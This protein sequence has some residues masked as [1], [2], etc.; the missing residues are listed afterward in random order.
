MSLLNHRDRNW[1]HI[2]VT[3]LFG[4]NYFSSLTQSRQD[5]SSPKYFTAKSRQKQQTAHSLAEA[6]LQWIQH[7]DIALFSHGVC[8]KET[9][10]RIKGWRELFDVDTSC[11][12]DYV[13]N[14]KM[15]QIK[16][17]KFRTRIN[18]TAEVKIC[19][20]VEYRWMKFRRVTWYELWLCTREWT[21]NIKEVNTKHNFFFFIFN[22][23]FKRDLICW[24]F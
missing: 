22:F 21:M 8:K 5:A 17:G 23:P 20:R 4:V 24:R 19:A 14:P 9:T 13:T 1:Y 2:N 16:Q 3:N 15:Y 11:M 12:D 18:N 10:W 7:R 6:V